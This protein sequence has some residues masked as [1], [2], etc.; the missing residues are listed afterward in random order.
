[1]PRVLP[2]VFSS[3]LCIGQTVTPGSAGQERYIFDESCVVK[4]TMECVEQATSTYSRV[5][6]GGA[7]LTKNVDTRV[8]IDSVCMPS[9]G[10]SATLPQIKG[11]EEAIRTI[12]AERVSNDVNTRGSVN[13]NTGS[14]GLKVCPVN[15]DQIYGGNN[16]GCSRLHG[17]LVS[18]TLADPGDPLS[19]RYFGEISQICETA[20]RRVPLSD[21]KNTCLRRLT[22]AEA[23]L[24]QDFINALKEFGTV[25]AGLGEQIEGRNA[26][27]TLDCPQGSNVRIVYAAEEQQSG[28]ENFRKW[29]NT[30]DHK[31]LTTLVY[32]EDGV[33]YQRLDGDNEYVT[34]QVFREEDRALGLDWHRFIQSA[35]A[36]EVRYFVVTDLSNSNFAGPK[37]P[38]EV[39]I[40]VPSS[41]DVASRPYLVSCEGKRAEQP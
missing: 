28:M 1:M 33:V 37:D 6:L 19:H 14:I 2:L 15:A 22:I 38:E 4:K 24:E 9:K 8:R 23:D 13:V 10:F 32:N 27:N 21:E 31:T 18:C 3:V 36:T 41:I 40:V 7:P 26:P 5:G 39:E 35:L 29:F 17:R 25:V 12:I 34:V 20:V 16:F 30:Q 11:A